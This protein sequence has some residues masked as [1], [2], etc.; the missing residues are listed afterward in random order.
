MP[1]LALAAIAALAVLAT[2][3]AAAAQRGSA[4][5]PIPLKMK[6][7]IDTAVVRGVLR[8]NVDCCAYVFE[9]AGGQKLYWTQSGA[10]ARM[11]LVQPDGQI[12]DP[13]LPNPADL[14]QTG[15][16]KLLVSPDLMADG[17]FGPF[18]LKLRIP[19][20]DR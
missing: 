4:S 13:G 11:G 1:K 7:G 16:Y 18:T 12:I 5:S 3:P 19:P 9:A 2:A 20:P 10:A 17:A 6:R 15:T 8:Q 14:S